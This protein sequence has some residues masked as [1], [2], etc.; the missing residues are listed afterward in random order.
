MLVGCPLWAWR[1]ALFLRKRASRPID[2]DVLL[3]ALLAAADALSFAL[4]I[5][6]LLL[7]LYWLI[8]IKM[9]VRSEA[10]C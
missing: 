9:Q 10:A 5:V 3:Y 7:S 6:L 8:S 1:M 4:C 2:L